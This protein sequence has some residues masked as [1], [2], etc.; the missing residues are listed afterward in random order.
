LSGPE[1]V[2]ALLAVALAGGV[3]GLTGFG[4]ALVSV[5]LLLLVLDPAAVVALNLLLAAA[6]NSVVV[7]D[8]WRYV[9]RRAVLSLLPW[10]AVGLP[11]GV[12]LLRVLDA[13]YIRLLA[14]AVVAAFALLLLRD[15]E[16]PGLRTRTGN[17]AAGLASGTLSTSTGLAG[18]PVV[19]LF[20]ARRFAK[21][22][23]RASNAAYFLAVSLAG[24]GLLFFRDLLSGSHLYLAVLLAPAA[25]GGKMLGTR[26]LGRVSDESFRNVTLG[27]VLLTGAVGIAGALYA[28]L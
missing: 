10:A 20:A 6:T 17:A 9:R 5:P 28:L 24:L 11:A 26:L 13:E 3:A 12:E 1:L 4:F 16:V 18:P 27:L 8:S 21:E 15:V 2:F 25:V 19:M 14:G 22:S 23:F 7:A